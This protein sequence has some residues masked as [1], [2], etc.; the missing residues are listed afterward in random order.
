MAHEIPK[1]LGCAMA[2]GMLILSA[3]PLIRWTKG[4]WRFGRGDDLMT[5]PNF[6]E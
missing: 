5:W 1:Y 4:W 6:A 3:Q 2:Q